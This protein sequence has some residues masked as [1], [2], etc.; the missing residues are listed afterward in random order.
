MQRATLMALQHEATTE[1]AF[2]LASFE[3]II[4]IHKHPSQ[5]MLGSVGTL[6][7]HTRRT[8]SY[9]LVCQVRSLYS[10][11]WALKCG[12]FMPHTWWAKENIVQNSFQWM[13]SVDW[14]NGRTCIDYYIIMWQG[15]KKRNWKLSVLFSPIE[16]FLAI[17]SQFGLKL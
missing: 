3:H 9:T 14:K 13:V 5:W 12:I 7:H 8:R 15:P 17:S 16:S 2:L 11:I 10:K 4:W 1:M 6:T